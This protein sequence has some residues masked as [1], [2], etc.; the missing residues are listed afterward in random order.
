MGGSSGS[1]GTGG[2]GGNG[3]G[4]AGGMVRIQA[5]LINATGGQINTRGGISVLG[6]TADFGRYVIAYEARFGADIGAVEGA[7]PEF[8]FPA[9][10][11]R[12][13]PFYESEEG[14]P[15]TSPI[16]GLVGGADAYGL[17][18]NTNILDPFFQDLLDNAPD[19]ASA[20][21]MRV[22]TNPLGDAYISDSL[23]MVNLTL[24]SLANPE[25]GILTAHTSPLLER[26]IFRDEDFGGSGAEILGELPA[27]AVYTTLAPTGDPNFPLVVSARV[28]G[29]SLNYATLFTGD[30]AYLTPGLDG[31]FDLDSDIDG[32]DFLSWQRGESP[33]PLSANDLADWQANFG[34]EAGSFAAS[35]T[36]PE[37]TSLALLAIS[38]L[39]GQTVVRHSRY[40]DC[41]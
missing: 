28:N 4:G 36:V 32:S 8:Y 11:H 29:A 26:G 10:L 17:L 23:L 15:F 12:K 20:A 19:N 37:P 7:A 39:L 25:F 21:V 38:L 1:G 18:D 24:G 9:D 41:V 34:A 6:G 14:A 16:A 30:F 33:D 27:G 31:D 35:Q 3:G 22:A 5:S 2:D 40:N 13:S